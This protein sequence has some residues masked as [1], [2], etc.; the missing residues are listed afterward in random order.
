[1][2][3]EYKDVD[4]GKHK[5][6][7]ERWEYEKVGKAANYDYGAKD[8]NKKRKD[9]DYDLVVDDDMIDFVQAFTIAGKTLNKLIGSICACHNMM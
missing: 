1:M 8:K 5:N 6:E 7:Q 9:K 2:P 3:T 4:D